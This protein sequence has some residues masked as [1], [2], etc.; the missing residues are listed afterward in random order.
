MYKPLFTIDTFHEKS[1]SRVH[2]TTEPGSYKDSAPRCLFKLLELG[3][4]DLGMNNIK[5]IDKVNLN[6]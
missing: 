2:S 6:R 5:K 3:T 1:L 4:L